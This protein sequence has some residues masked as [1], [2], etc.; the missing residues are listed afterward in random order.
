MIGNSNLSE[1]VPV[2]QSKY[3]VEISEQIAAGSFISHVLNYE[4]AQEPNNKAHAAEIKDILRNSIWNVEVVEHL[5]V[6]PNADPIPIPLIWRT[7][8]TRSSST[9]NYYTEAGFIYSDNAIRI[10]TRQM[11]Q[12]LTTH[13]RSTH[14]EYGDWKLSYIIS[15]AVDVH[16]LQASTDITNHNNVIILP[17]TNPLTSG[18]ALVKDV[19]VGNDDTADEGEEEEE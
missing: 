19:A 1:V 8:A 11:L 6:R 18:P 14:P 2:D 17:H 10:H 15:R 13:I 5:P 12:R 7:P 16:I 9:S 3:V 4:F